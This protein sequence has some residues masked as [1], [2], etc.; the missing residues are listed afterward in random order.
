MYSKRELDIIK[1]NGKFLGELFNILKDVV[2]PGISTKEIDE[3]IERKIKKYKAIPSFKGYMGYPAVSCISIN[4]ELVHG[5]PK[6]NKIVKEGDIVSIDVGIYKNGFHVDAARTYM[7]GKVTPEK[8]RIVEVCESSFYYAIEN[9]KVGDTIGDL[10]YMIQ[11]FVE[12]HG[13]SVIRDLVGHGVGRNLHEEPQ[14]PNYGIP[15]TGPVIYDNMVLAI[16]PMISA[17]SYEIKIDPKDGWTVTTID[18]SLTAHY[19]NTV[20]FTKEG[21]IIV[22]KV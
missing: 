18:D 16:E 19:E 3:F 7:I 15:N 13:Y 6:R 17:G 10:G 4:K 12:K 1:E 2:K 14:V 9:I 20:I 21:N 8:K 22:T 5:I 11:S